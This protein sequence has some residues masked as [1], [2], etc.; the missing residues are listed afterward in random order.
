LDYDRSHEVMAYHN[1]IHASVEYAIEHGYRRVSYGPLNN[2]TKRRAGTD[3][4]PVV[5][6]LWL[7]RPFLHWFTAK[8]VVPHLDVYSGRWE[9]LAEDPPSPNAPRT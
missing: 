3:S 1:L 7:R 6:S 5:A 2:E 8:F 4:M 9:E